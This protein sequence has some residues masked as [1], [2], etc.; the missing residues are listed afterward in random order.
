MKKIT[1]VLLI[2]FI[3]VLIFGTVFSS[4]AEP[5]D[6]YTYSIDGNPL[7]S[8]AAYSAV[9]EFDS[10]DMGIAKLINSKDSSISLSATASDIVTDSNGNLYI[11]DRGNN[12]IVILNKYYEA[13]KIIETYKDETGTTKKFNSPAGLFIDNDNGMYVC[14]TGNKCIV[15][16]DSNYEHVKTIEKPDSSVLSDEAFVPTS[17]AVD[18]YGRVFVVSTAAYEGVIVLSSEG[19]FTGFIGAQEVSYTA[20][21]KIWRRFQSAE[22][23]KGQATKLATAYNNIA[24]DEDGFVYVTTN[25]TDPN[26]MKNQYSAIKSKKASYSPVKKLNAQG[27]E[28]M[29]RNG[30]F[31]PGGEVD[32]DI[33][34]VSNI[35]DVA[36]GKEKSWTILD[37]S[38]SRFF[39]YDQNGNLLF[40][41]GGNGDQLGQ[42]MNLVG[43]TY[44]VV[45]DEYRLIALDRTGTSCSITVYSP[46]PYYDAIMLALH[47]ENAHLY[48]ESQQNWQDVLTLNNNFDLAYIGI[49]KALYNQ[50]MHKEAM[51][52]LERAYETNI[53]S[54]AS[55]SATK[56]VMTVWLFPI[57][58]L[59]IGLCVG[60]AFFLG[61]AKKKNKAATLKVGRKTYVEEL[62]Y[63]FHLP[64]HPFD[65]FW[66]LKHEKRGS[67]R[68]A[69]TVIGITIASFFY[70]SIGRGYVFNPRGETSN[71][72]AQAAIIIIPFMLFCIANWCLTT[73]FDGEGS[74]KDIFIAAGYSLAPLPVFTV[75]ATILTNVLGIN[76]QMII[77]LVMAIGY[78]WVAM[79]L[80]FGTLVTHDY[81]M[82]KNVIM[83]VCTLVAMAVIAFIVVLFFSLMVKMGSFVVSV[84]TEIAGRL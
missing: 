37:S 63:V 67:V 7:K 47:N 69:I 25:S 18:K 71:I 57:M 56:D 65:G 46:T 74:F 29:K 77:T 24:V 13:T 66:D 81:Q 17:V 60:I 43:M 10:V 53:W 23:R 80:F 41:F 48:H 78:I 64:F 39:T 59:V 34:T 4:A 26:N 75:V 54:K 50:G 68:G 58:I 14:D 55:S 36:V 1:S 73:L 5:Y 51:D 84:F 38:R 28:I 72:L 33:K 15:V 22:Q 82:K 6:T 62:F 21:Q 19:D 3:A 9:D 83:L 31:D 42:G 12:R 45:G 16:F 61:Y 11:A 27:R 79:L 52:Y 70:Q 2:A 35:I 32:V 44:H 20:M 30:F 40:A 76:A 49:G 8:P